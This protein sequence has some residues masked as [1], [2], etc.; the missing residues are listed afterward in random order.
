MLTHLRTQ[1]PR[2]HSLDMT[3]Q[4]K[5]MLLMRKCKTSIEFWGIYDK[6]GNNAGTFWPPPSSASGELVV[7]ER[8]HT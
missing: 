8:W 5:I 3:S 4:S 2:P 6:I 7:M 1:N